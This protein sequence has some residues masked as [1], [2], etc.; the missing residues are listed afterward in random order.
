MSRISTPCVGTCW[1]DPTTGRC[2]GC[3][4]TRKEIAD[5]CFITEEERLAIMATLQQRVEG[6]PPASPQAAV[7]PD[8]T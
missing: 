2:D 8:P 6:P 5:W 7:G 4:R 1:I 3:R